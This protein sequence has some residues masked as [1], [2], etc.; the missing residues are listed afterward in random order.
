MWEY[1]SGKQ[2]RKVRLGD[3]EKEAPGLYHKQ[4]DITHTHTHNTHTYTHTH[5]HTHTHSLS[6]T[7]LSTHT[8]TPHTHQ[9]T[10]THAH[11]RSLDPL[12]LR[13]N[14]ITSPPAIIRHSVNTQK[15][16][17]PFLSLSVE[18]I[19]ASVYVYGNNTAIIKMHV[20]RLHLYHFTVHCLF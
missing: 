14:G 10:H 13:R 11:T 1:M 18:L 17:D 6:A 4:L 5:T 8:H 15:P 19:T 3:R 2:G 9:H 7:H 16:H 12:I 20:Q